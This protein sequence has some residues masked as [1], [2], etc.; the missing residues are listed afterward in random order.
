MLPLLP[1]AATLITIVVYTLCDYLRR[2]G[3]PRSQE[4]DLEADDASL[5]PS[6]V[7]FLPQGL[8]GE[9]DGSDDR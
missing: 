3:P 7:Y 9:A 6:S 4:L 5:G 8:L 1:V 2:H